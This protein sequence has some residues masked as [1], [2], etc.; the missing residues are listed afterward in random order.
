MD[1]TLTYEQKAEHMKQWWQ[2]NLGDFS[3]LSLNQNDF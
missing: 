3:A 1:P 2:Q